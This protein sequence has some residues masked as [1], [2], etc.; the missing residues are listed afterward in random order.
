MKISAKKAVTIG[1]TVKDDAGEILD[2]SMGTD[3]L[4]YLHGLGN[5]VPGLERALEGKSAGDNVA[6]SL[7]PADGYGAR[8]ESLR[9]TIPLRQLQVDDKRKVKVGGRYRAW[10]A[11]G[12]HVVEV[13]AI[14]GDQVTVDGN[15][16]LAGMTLHFTVDVVE[17]RNATAD[18]L[19]HGHVHGPGGH[20]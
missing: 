4:T 12:A 16:P 11:G 14:D 10:L 17:V 20:H 18:E 7:P 5:I 13:T 9:Q 1:Y 6:V 8:D 19:A 3:P 2:T 15:H